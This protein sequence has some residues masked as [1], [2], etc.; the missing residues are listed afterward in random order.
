LFIGHIGHFGL[1]EENKI[2]KKKGNQLAMEKRALLA[3]KKRNNIK[4]SK[5]NPQAKEKERER[6]SD[7]RQQKGRQATRLN[8][9]G[10]SFREEDLQS[11]E[12]NSEFS[13]LSSLSFYLSA[14][15]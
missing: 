6:D 9:N 10:G 2:K 7:G 5:A 15:Q 1:V 11:G 14:V 13:S 3:K 12:L 8:A 4:Q